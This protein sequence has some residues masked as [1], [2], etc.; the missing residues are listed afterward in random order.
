MLLSEKG[1]AAEAID[2][3]VSAKY[4]GVIFPKYARIEAD[5]RE[6]EALSNLYAAAQQRHERGETGFLDE[7]PSWIFNLLAPGIKLELYCGTEISPTKLVAALR[8]ARIGGM[9]TVVLYYDEAKEKY[10]P[11]L[12]SSEDGDAVLLCF[13]KDKDNWIFRI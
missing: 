2:G 1:Q 3:V 13:W 4:D 6:A 12:K 10:L 9:E 11:L 7:D 5:R 8:A